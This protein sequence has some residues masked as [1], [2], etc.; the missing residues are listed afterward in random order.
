[1]INAKFSAH[2]LECLSLD[3]GHILSDQDSRYSQMIYYVLKQELFCSMV[4]IPV[5]FLSST[6]FM[7]YSIA[8]KIN[9]LCIVARGKGPR[10]SIPHC[11]K[12]QETEIRFCS[13]GDP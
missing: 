11:A 9:F 10:M 3:F 13:I 5:I 6:H 2:L 7:M 8:I 12:D 4:V 1:M